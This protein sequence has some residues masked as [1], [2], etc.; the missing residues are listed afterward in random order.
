VRQ[1]LERIQA[2][3]EKLEKYLIVLA[4]AVASPKLGGPDPSALVGAVIKL[5]A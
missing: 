5:V 3:V 1:R 2:R 4:C